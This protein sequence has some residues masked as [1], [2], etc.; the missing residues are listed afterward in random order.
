MAVAGMLN[1]NISIY[2]QPAQSPD[3]NVDDLGFFRAIQAFMDRCPT[4]EFELIEAVLEA[5][6]NYNYVL[7]NRVFLTLQT[8]MNRIIEENGGNNYKIPHMG[9]AAMERAGTLPMVIGVTARAN[10]H[11]GD[12]NLAVAV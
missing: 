11:L 4:N 7:I 8:C 10:D 12:G 9:K 2:T 1:L 5:Y 3:L 6:A